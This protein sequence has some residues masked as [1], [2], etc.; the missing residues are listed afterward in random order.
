MRLAGESPAAEARF[1]RR[2]PHVSKAEAPVI[3]P[4][5][6]RLQLFNRK[7]DKLASFSLYE[8][9]TSKATTAHVHWERDKGWEAVFEGPG[10]EAL[11]A[12][13]LTLR[14]FMQDNDPVSLANMRRAYEDPR[15]PPDIREAF[16]DTTAKLNAFLDRDTNVAVEASRKLTHRDVLN[17]FVYGG[18][19]HSNPRYRAMFESLAST[20]FMAVLQVDFVN[21]VGTFVTA[22]RYMANANKQALEALAASGG[23]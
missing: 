15:M 20:P 9:V 22:L 5:V 14:Q 18:L 6:D 13:V 8:H 4:L 23:A 17:I 3:D 16:C 11:D 7:V 10:V 1:V 21:A 2:T 19:A 12:T